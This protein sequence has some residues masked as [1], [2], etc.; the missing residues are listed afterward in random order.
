MNKEKYV[1]VLITSLLCGACRTFKSNVWPTLSK[2]LENDQDIKI[3]QLEVPTI[4]LAP[5][6]TFGD[7]HKDLYKFVGWF[8]TM[9]MFRKDRFEDLNTPLEGV[10]MYGKPINGIMIMDGRPI[11]QETNILNWIDKTKQILGNMKVNVNTGKEALVEIRSEPV[12]YR[13]RPTKINN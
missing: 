9:M 12:T 7:Y 3:I 4:Q 2:K 10:V 6:T 5:N 1:Y 8:P 13:F 11:Y